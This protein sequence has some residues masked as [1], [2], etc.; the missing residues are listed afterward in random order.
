M[1]YPPKL[2]ADIDPLAYATAK[3]Y[4]LQEEC[5][6][7]LESLG[8]TEGEIKLPKHQSHR[9]EPPQPIAPGQS[10]WPLLPT[11]RSILEK[12][13]TE[14]LGNDASPTSLTNGYGDELDTFEAGFKEPQDS[15]A[16]H[17]DMMEENW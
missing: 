6:A 7:I 8:M 1:Y 4:G 5:E 10:N 3:T 15:T 9:L 11:S 2:V 13:L 14:E 17:D 16:A 12:A